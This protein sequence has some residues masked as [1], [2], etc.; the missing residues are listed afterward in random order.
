MKLLLAIGPEIP[1]P[2]LVLLQSNMPT[3]EVEQCKNQ[4]INESGSVIMT[5]HNCLEVRKEGGDSESGKGGLYDAKIVPNDV[6]T[7]LHGKISQQCSH[8]AIDRRG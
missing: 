5:Q 8:R 1:R 2:R 3:L 6:F 7:H 4:K